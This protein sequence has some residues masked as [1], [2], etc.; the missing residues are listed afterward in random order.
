MARFKF[1]HAADIHL[2]SILHADGMNDNSKLQELCHEATYM[3]FDNLCSLAI[4]AQ[5]CF[6]L[7]SG[8]VY[9][10]EARS[11]RANR[12]FVDC[13]NKLDEAGIQ[14]FILA[15]NHDPAR[16]YQEM[17]SLPGNTHLLPADR[18][19]IYY[20]RDQ[21]GRKIAAIAGQSYGNR[22]EKSAL[23][24]NYPAPDKGVF[25]IAMLH[26]QLE[27][28]K[29]NYIPSSLS[30]MADNPSFDYWALG[31]IHKPQL[32]RGE[33][34]VI[35][36]AG[37][38][39]GRDFGEQNIGGCWLV[40]VD[41]A[42]VDSFTYWATSPVE[43]QTLQI[44]IGCPELKDADS[45][46]ELGDYMLSCARDRLSNG[47]RRPDFDNRGANYRLKYALDDIQLKGCI[48]RWEIVGRGNLHSYLMND[49]Q[50]S[51]EEL[52]QYLRDV[53]G[54]QETFIWTDS[55]KIRTA[56]PITAKVL[57]QHPTLKQLLEHVM[58]S[59][60]EDPNIRR[61]FIS[62]L[63][64]AWTTTFEHEE[65]DDERLYLDEKTLNNIMEDAVQLLLEG[66]VEGGE[67]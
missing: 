52:C 39:Q 67:A 54:N 25:R 9:D 13:C 22:Q 35:A 14:V 42:K 18:P 11:V 56:N 64:S 16:E 12:F 34:P 40:E 63:G 3:A 53:L 29:S 55:V 31:H 20:V 51:E 43:Y 65:Q 27:A 32:L 7:L 30:E 2:G 24:L 15:G 6:L 19:E 62:R 8:D 48:L 49:R 37:A 61:K 28:G 1:I 44:D 50:G 58:H 33:K 17:F 38:P 4:Q 41:Q 5:A 10:R 45:L 21:Q 36:Y 26:T 60:E 23:H 57:D 47:R 59:L 66:L 46:D